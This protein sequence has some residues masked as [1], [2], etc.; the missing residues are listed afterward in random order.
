MQ[1]SNPIDSAAPPEPVHPPHQPVH[2][3]PRG[4]GIIAWVIIA[5]SS[6][7]LIW[8]ANTSHQDPIAR[9]DS[10]SAQFELTGKLLVAAADQLSPQWKPFIFGQAASLKQSKRIAERLAYAVLVAELKGPAD[11][12]SEIEELEQQ[13]IAAEQESSHA[14]RT[15]Q[16]IGSLKLIFEARV[17]NR[18]Y[19]ISSEERTLLETEL[20]WFGVLAPVTSGTSNLTERQALMAPLQ[21]IPLT[22]AALVLWYIVCGFIGFASLIAVA[23]LAFLRKLAHHFQPSGDGAIYAET[24]A[25]WLMLFLGLRRAALMLVSSQNAILLNMCAALLSITAIAWPWIRGIGWSKIRRDIGL[26]LPEHPFRELLIGLLSYCTALPFFVIGFVATAL[27]MLL[28]KHLAPDAPDPS[29]PVQEALVGA[30]FATVIQIMVLGVVI[31]PISEEIMFRGVL[32]RNLRDTTQRFRFVASFLVSAVISSFVFSAIHPQGWVT[33]PVLMGLAF[34]FCVAREWRGSLMAS[35]IAHAT[36]NFVT[37]S[38][39]VLLFS[40]A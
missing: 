31:A 30:D 23:V 16:L 11:A 26:Y 27:L 35:M 17:E 34:G 10:I 2:V 8:E 29:H 19:E 7:F 5:L 37:L 22:L 36:T 14:V 40:N 32:F 38:L 18:E 9:Q 15:S 1:L 12:L 21:P 28:Q 39:N 3:S 24:F 6:G 4:Y 13:Q 20:G 33:I 25:I